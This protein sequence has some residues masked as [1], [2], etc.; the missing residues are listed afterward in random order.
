MSNDIGLGRLCTDF[1]QKDAVHVAVVPVVAGQALYPGDSV[2]L[3][4]KKEAVK[5]KYSKELR[6]G[7]VD[8]FLTNPINKG[9]RFYLMLL[10]GSIKSIRHD[11]THSALPEVVEDAVKVRAGRWLK[12]YADSIASSLEELLMRTK[13]FLDCG[14]YWNEGERFDGKWVPEEFWK[15][16]EEY[17]GTKVDED[18]KHSFFSCSC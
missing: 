16:Y 6:I 15:Y 17:T 2:A 1:A 11:W 14:D 7:V 8:C 9:E 13:D 3:N 12:D 5:V 10:P 4:D 18:D